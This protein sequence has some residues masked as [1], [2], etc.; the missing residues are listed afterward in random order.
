MAFY[1]DHSWVRCCGVDLLSAVLERLPLSTV[2]QNMSALVVPLSDII[3]HP[4]QQTSRGNNESPS[5][6]DRFR[7]ERTTFHP[8]RTNNYSVSSKLL[9]I[10]EGLLEDASLAHFA[11]LC[12]SKAIAVLRSFFSDPDNFT[13]NILQSI[14]YVS[15]AS[16]LENVFN[17]FDTM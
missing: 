3:D 1:C 7:M 5:E 10:F 4:P 2:H 11:T 16:E 9:D 6:V 12:R 15:E 14:P 8:L 13:K 17:R